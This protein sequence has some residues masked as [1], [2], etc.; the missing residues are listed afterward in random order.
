MSTFLSPDGKTAQTLLLWRHWSARIITALLTRRKRHRRKKTWWTSW[1][2]ENG[3]K[4][5]VPHCLLPAS[6]FLKGWCAAEL[7]FFFQSFKESPS[8]SLFTRDSRMLMTVNTVIYLSI[9]IEQIIG[10]TH[11]G[12]ILGAMFT[13]QLLLS[14]NETLG[15]RMLWELPWVRKGVLIWGPFLFYACFSYVFVGLLLI[16]SDGNVQKWEL[17]MLHRVILIGLADQHCKINKNEK[18]P[19]LLYNALM[20]APL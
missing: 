18:H 7:H 6:A 5:H 9:Y 4:A 16:V 15:I 3:W 8:L 19:F 12:N 14:V 10:N 13:F 1:T 20:L 17:Y 2:H 11:Q